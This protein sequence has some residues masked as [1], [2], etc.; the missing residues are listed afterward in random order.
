MK[1]LILE[2]CFLLSAFALMADTQPMEKTVVI[3]MGPPGSGKGTQAVRIKDQLNIPHISTGNILRDHIRN[4]T[5][6][7]I[8][9]KE[10]MDAGKLVPDS[11]IIDLLFDRVSNP[12]AVKGYLLD[13]FP[14]TI[15]QAEAFDQRLSKNSHLV[16]INLQVSDELVVKRISGR[17]SCPSCGCVYNRFFDAP[18]EEGKCTKCGAALVQRADDAE[19][20]VRERLSVY[21]T[22]TEPLV[23]YY[24]KKNVLINING[25]QDPD[26]V[27]EE[28]KRVL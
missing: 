11:L 6:L 27:F 3:L 28:I 8:K 14:R 7:G 24:K 16:V 1:H 20:V 12:D 23:E 10:Y 15:P 2:A 26:K 4:N 9:A 22:Q 21:K 13:G 25:E 5:P 18:R 17:L 19:V